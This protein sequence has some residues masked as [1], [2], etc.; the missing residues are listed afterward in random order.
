MNFKDN[1][2]DLRVK[3]G[4][5]QETLAKQMNIPKSTLRNWEQGLREPNKLIIIEQLTIIL[6]CDYNQLLGSY[7][8]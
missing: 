6:E 4:Y 2:K 3:R 7:S 5:T 8:D 1:L